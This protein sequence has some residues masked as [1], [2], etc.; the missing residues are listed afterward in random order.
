MGIDPVTHEPL[1]KQLLSNE[2]PLSDSHE[3][4]N[5]CVAENDSIINSEAHSSSPTENCSSDDSLLL[6]K[7]C[8]NEPLVNSLWLEEA[9][10]V[11][12]TWE[13]PAGSLPSMEENCAWLL[14]CQDFGIHDFGL[15]CFSD[16]E[17]NVMKSN[18]HVEAYWSW[19]DDD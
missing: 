2:A 16:I 8:K 3:S 15:D 1:Q 5:H 12:A 9:P 4:G 13:N 11:D 17:F 14:D 6:D 18:W 10:L 19:T 7:V